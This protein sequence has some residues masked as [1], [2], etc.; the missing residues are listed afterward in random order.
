VIVRKPACHRRKYSAHLP[1][2]ITS[3]SSCHHFMRLPRKS[4]FR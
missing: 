3:D 4:H 1:A 2:E